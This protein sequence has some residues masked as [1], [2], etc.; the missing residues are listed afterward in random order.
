MRIGLTSG[1][2]AGIGL[3]VLMKALPRFIHEADW[4]L[5]G[6]AADFQTA[7]ERYQPGLPWRRWRSGPGD[8]SSTGCLG[9]SSVG[10]GAEAIAPGEGSEESGARALASLDAAARAARANQIDA[11]VTAPLSKQFAGPGF[12]GQTEF[13]RD[14][15]EAPE[16]A[17]S[18]FT[19]AFKVVLATTHMSLRQALDRLSRELYTRLLALV[20]R[21]IRGLGFPPPRIAVAGVNPHAGESG[22]FGSEEHELLEP[23]VRASRAAGIDVSGP[24]PADSCYLRAS[25]GEFD[26]VLAP[27]HDQGLIPVKLIAPGES[28][29]VT[30]GLPCIRTSPDHGTAFGIAGQGKASADGMESAIR[31]ALELAS[32][33]SIRSGDGYY[34]GRQ[35]PQSP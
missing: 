33:R 10:P 21:E 24:W 22:M 32:R 2:P 1:D 11:I 34:R 12:T 18:F 23:A 20:D 7:V 9:F 31:W 8:V 27:Y 5:F 17:M 16:V 15:L 6:C 35:F 13:L 19:P 29:N 28:A 14:L 4:V 3:E 30:L 26:V 25:R